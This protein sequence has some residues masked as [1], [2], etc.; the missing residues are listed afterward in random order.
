MEWKSK[1]RRRKAARQTKRMRVDLAWMLFV[2]QVA[3]G[4]ETGAEAWE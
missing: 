1:P 2:E 4:A 3:I